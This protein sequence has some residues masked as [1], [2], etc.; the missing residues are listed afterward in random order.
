MRRWLKWLSIP[1][2]IILLAGGVQ[3]YFWYQIRSDID[4]L[5][6]SIRPFAKVEYGN[7]SFSLLGRVDVDQITI[8]P[9][10]SKQKVSIQQMSLIAS[11]WTFFLT[12]QEQF[13]SG[14]L[15]EPLSL[16]F[17]GLRYDLAATSTLDAR[18]AH[19]STVTS[20]DLQDRS[21]EMLL[22]GDTYQLNQ[23]TL[24]AMGYH[25]LKGGF[26]LLL[27]PSA[28]NKLMKVRVSAEFPELLKGEMN[29][30]LALHQGGTLR[31]EDLAKTAIQMFGITLSDLGYNQRWKTYCSQ[32]AVIQ[33]ELYL[34][35]Y[36]SALADKLGDKGQETDSPLL[37]AF[38]SA[39]GARSIVAARLEP[40]VPL[41]LQVLA[42]AEGGDSLFSSSEFAIQVNGK[43]LALGE[44]DWQVMS[45]LLGGDMRQAVSAVVKN[46]HIVSVVKKLPEVAYMKE[47]IPGVMPI[48]PP[49]V[50]KAFLKTPVNDLSG[51]VGSAVKLRTFFGRDLEGTLVDVTP[52]GISLRHQMEQ[53][54]ATFPVAKDKIALIEVYR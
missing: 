22:C 8:Q 29:L 37:D 19:S 30:W 45:D 43:E 35:R 39:R 42:S 2:V 51:Y 34:E 13:R 10:A 18:T 32:Q 49:E 12:A 15:R 53:G 41:E 5:I 52:D 20:A 31:R 36:R 4:D 47:I 24:Q 17:S 27:E 38:A 9:A 33:P 46:E 40:A 28:N 1:L 21:L 54:R 25:Y 16:N 23:N 3:G 7:I 26:D 6:A 44:R 50:M 14:V 11:S 48:R